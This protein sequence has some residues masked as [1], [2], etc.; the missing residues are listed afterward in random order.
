MR[1]FLAQRAGAPASIQEIMNGIEP[2][3]GKAPSSSYRSALQ[4]ER[5][6]KRISRGVF[7]LSEGGW[8]GIGA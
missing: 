3:I 5:Y 6:F 4:D 7:V 2:L 1:M 8:G